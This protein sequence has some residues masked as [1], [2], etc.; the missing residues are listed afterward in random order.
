M[1]HTQQQ[2]HKSAQRPKFKPEPWLR[3]E[4]MR[5]DALFVYIFLFSVFSSYLEASV[6]VLLLVVVF[7]LFVFAV[8]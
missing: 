6:W 8:I 3:A 5:T 2:A 7:C 1:M 4:A